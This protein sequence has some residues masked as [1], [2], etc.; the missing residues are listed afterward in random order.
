MTVS[1]EEIS[2]KKCEVRIGDVELRGDNKGS[3]NLRIDGDSY[4]FSA[5]LH[6]TFRF[7]DIKQAKKIALAILEI[8][9]ELE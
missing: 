2:Y 4:M 7:T 8:V 1:C 6:N 5:R 9:E 3:C